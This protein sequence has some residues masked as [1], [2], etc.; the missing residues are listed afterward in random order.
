MVE[1]LAKVPVVAVLPP[2]ADNIA[3]SVE[4]LCSLYQEI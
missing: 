3:I 4:R 2:K 1:R